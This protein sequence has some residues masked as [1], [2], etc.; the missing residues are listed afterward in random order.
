MKLADGPTPRI[1]PEDAFALTAVPA[2]GYLLLKFIF[3]F[4]GIQ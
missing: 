2:F 1:T 4:W 3:P